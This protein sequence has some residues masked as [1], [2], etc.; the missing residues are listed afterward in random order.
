MTREE[1]KK[2]L[3]MKLLQKSFHRE[4]DNMTSILLGHAVSIATEVVFEELESRTCKA[5]EDRDDLINTL[6]N[7]CIRLR[8]ELQE[9]DSSFERI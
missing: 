2:N 1:F 8:Q 5:I 3:H 9:Y 4:S 6:N 7:E